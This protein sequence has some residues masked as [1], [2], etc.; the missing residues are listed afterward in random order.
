MKLLCVGQWQP[1]FT[2]PKDST[3]IDI[4]TP[5]EG[6]LTNYRREERSP[7][8]IFYEPVYSGVCAV[9]DATHWMPIPQP[10]NDRTELRHDERNKT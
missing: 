1:I 4:W 3:I 10:P 6:R 5:S 8:N 9:R 2:A 7:T